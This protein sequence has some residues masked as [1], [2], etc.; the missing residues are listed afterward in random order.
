MSEV[1]KEKL[2][3]KFGTTVAMWNFWF[4]WPHLFG[5]RLTADSSRHGCRREPP[6]ILVVIFL[7]TSSRFLFRAKGSIGQLH[8]VSVRTDSEVFAGLS[9]WSTRVFCSHWA[10]LR[11]P[12]RESSS[13]GFSFPVYYSKPEISPV[14]SCADDEVLGYLEMS[15]SYSHY[16]PALFEFYQFDIQNT[17]KVSQWRGVSVRWACC[18]VC[19]RARGCLCVMCVYVSDLCACVHNGIWVSHLNVT[20]TI[21]VWSLFQRLLSS[22][23]AF[24]RRP[25]SRHPCKLALNWIGTGDAQ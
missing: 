21:S 1:C 23:D 6:V 15:H 25:G 8:A 13:T 4:Q 14:H 5:S 2:H 17:G 22:F 7:D 10:H 16:A 20:W 19:L 3:T 12:G 24:L 18:S 11:T 9:F